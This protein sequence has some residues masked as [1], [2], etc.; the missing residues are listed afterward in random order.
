MAPHEWLTVTCPQRWTRRRPT[1]DD[2]HMGRKK[3]PT[4]SSPFIAATTCSH[5]TRPPPAPTADS[6]PPPPHRGPSKER[7][8]TR[9]KHAQASSFLTCLDV[10]RN[11]G[12][13]RAQ[14]VLVPTC[15]SIKTNWRLMGQPG[16][17][18]TA[19]RKNDTTIAVQ[20]CYTG[21]HLGHSHAHTLLNT[22]TPPDEHFSP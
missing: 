6:P 7:A 20:S 4:T 1:A 5:T 14:A 3:C 19:K 21:A 2:V 12:K 18:K 8:R 10:D 16:G 9:S 13:Q 17:S 11:K 15:S 22:C